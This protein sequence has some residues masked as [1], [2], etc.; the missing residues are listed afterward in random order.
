MNRKTSCVKIQ[1]DP[2]K[3][4]PLNSCNFCYKKLK[5]K[6]T[7]R[8]HFKTC[9]IKN[10]GMG[11]L[12]AKI[13][14]LTTSNQQL[15]NKVHKLEEKGTDV[16]EYKQIINGNNNTTINTVN[17]I[18]KNHNNTFLNF[19]IV[20]YA[21]RES[22]DLMVE[23]M[24]VEAPRILMQAPEPDI[25]Q[26]EQVKSRIQDLVGSVYRNPDY[27]QLQNVY[28]TDTDADKDNAFQYDEGK[29]YIT[30][31]N[32]LSKELLKKIYNAVFDSN[33][34]KKSEDVMKVMKHV[35]VIAGL[36]EQP[37]ESMSPAEVVDLYTAIGQ[38]LQFST[39]IN[40]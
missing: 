29:W 35:F 2:T 32:T 28:V 1:G 12:F 19:N 16:V 3:Q 18:V 17:N 21:G 25:S 11:I 5:N 20:N 36:G 31:W 38:N 40:V 14:E 23:I 39:I 8:R 7:L 6:A 10:G 27:K 24:K 9:P 15:V 26:T 22:R 34:V 37:V 13:K 33:N 30:D 4:T